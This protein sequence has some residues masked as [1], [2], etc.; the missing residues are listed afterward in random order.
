MPKL[1]QAPIK[2]RFEVPAHE[3][4]VH[5]KRKLESYRALWRK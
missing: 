2:D 4:D 3:C 1:Y 5:D